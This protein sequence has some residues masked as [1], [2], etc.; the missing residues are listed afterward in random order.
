MRPLRAE[1]HIFGLQSDGGMFTYSVDRR[2]D[3]THAKNPLNIW[4]LQRQVPALKSFLGLWGRGRLSTDPEVASGWLGD[5]FLRINSGN[6]PSKSELQKAAFL[7]LSLSPGSYLAKLRSNAAEFADAMTPQY[8]HLLSMVD[9]SLPPRSELIFHACHPDVYLWIPPTP[10]R[11]KKLIVCFGTRKNTLNAPRPLVHFELAKAD[12]GILYVGH[13]P[14]HDVSKGLI[15]RDLKSTAALLLSITKQFG[16]EKLYGLGTSL[17]GYAALHYAPLM[18][19]ER[20]LNYSGM[21]IDHEQSVPRSSDRW[22]SEKNFPLDR[23]LTVLSSSD[24]TDRRILDF[25]NGKGFKTPRDWVSFPSHGSLTSSI[26]ERK[27]QTQLSWL[28]E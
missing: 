12:I 10:E 26:L 9:L 8:R 11:P 25:Y 22:L 27:F 13:R 3:E 23:I 20:V 24:N 21:P 1:H 15:G 14:D 17:G 2:F 28:I 5:V 19:F 18:H 4:T 16:F 6:I 7:I